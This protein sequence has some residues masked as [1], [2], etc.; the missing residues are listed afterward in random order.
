MALGVKMAS[1][2]E[3]LRE[4]KEK[5]PDFSGRIIAV[6]KYVDENKIIEAYEAGLRDFG[7]NKVQDALKKL[8]NLPENLKKDSVWHFIGHLQSNKVRKVVGKFDYIH[9]VDTLELAKKISAVAKELGIIQKILIEVNISQEKSKFG[10]KEE[11][12]EEIFK[13][14]KNLDGVEIVGLMTMAPH[15]PN[16]VFLKKVFTNLYDLSYNLQCRFHMELKE[17][18]M[19]MSSDYEIAVKSGSTMIRLGQRLFN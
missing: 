2:R 4:V 14:A 19:G 16:E 3:N 15:T 1:V 5:I 7:E 11:D 12:V 10:I 6:T 17:L 18:S 8:E 13:N 9:S